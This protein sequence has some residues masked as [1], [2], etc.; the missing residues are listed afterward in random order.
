MNFG[1]GEHLT[2]PRDPMSIGNM[3]DQWSFLGKKI[4]VSFSV[5]STGNPVTAASEELIPDIQWSE[6]QQRIWTEAILLT[7]LGKR[8]VRGIFWSCFQDP[9]APSDLI[10]GL[11]SGLVNTQQTL[12][13]AFKHFSAARKNLLQ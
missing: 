7:L 6:E 3:I 4:Y 11:N 13:P 10:T 5:P 12:K 9:T 1:Y 8:A 2:L